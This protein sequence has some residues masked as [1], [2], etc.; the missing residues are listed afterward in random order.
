[1]NEVKKYTH[2]AKDR[3][4]LFALGHFS[5]VSITISHRI[6]IS[7]LTEREG[8]FFRRSL[9]KKK[10]A[11]SLEDNITHHGRNALVLKRNVGVQLRIERRAEF[12]VVRICLEQ[13]GNG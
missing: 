9:I 11:G 5:M 1:M 13:R 3:R 6:V 2:R 7:L 10:A 8:S 4:I 12:G